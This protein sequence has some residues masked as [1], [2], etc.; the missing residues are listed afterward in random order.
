[1]KKG[2][3]YGYGVGY[4]NRAG[5]GGGVAVRWEAKLNY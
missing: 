4:L 5:G 3:E 2:S 1:M